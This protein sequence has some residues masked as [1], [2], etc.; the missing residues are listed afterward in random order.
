M[1]EHSGTLWKIVFLR[2][3]PSR[4]SRGDAMPRWGS[5][6][7][8]RTIGIP[9]LVRF[10][11][12]SVTR[13]SSLKNRVDATNP[14]V[15]LVI[16]QNQ[17]KSLGILSLISNCITTPQGF[18]ASNSNYI[19]NQMQFITVTCIFRARHCDVPCKTFVDTFLVSNFWRVQ[20][21][22][23]SKSIRICPK[24]VKIN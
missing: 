12:Q 8:V 10:E 18:I 24:S 17:Y 20:V 2:P 7:A 9:G 21:Q 11:H 22:R 1:R 14:Q 15:F 23:E 6:E 16:H 4:T 13:C 5:R 19:G 3:V